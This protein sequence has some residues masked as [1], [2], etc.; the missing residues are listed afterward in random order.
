MNK[1]ERDVAF[2]IDRNSFPVDCPELLD[3]I[4]LTDGYNHVEVKTDNPTVFFKEALHLAEIYEL[5]VP[6][7]RNFYVRDKLKVEGVSLIVSI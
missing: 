2:V 7:T 5:V 3:F 4:T 1:D 6:V